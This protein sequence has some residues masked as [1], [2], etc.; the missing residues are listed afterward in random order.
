M[1]TYIGELSSCEE[2]FN[3]Y[4]DVLSEMIGR[5]AVSEILFMNLDIDRGVT[6]FDDLKDILTIGFYF[7][8]ELSISQN[9]T[10]NSYSDEENYGQFLLFIKDTKLKKFKFVD[11]HL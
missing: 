3:F 1:S 7:L 4:L 8:Q 2:A 9:Y 6:S 11:Q 10:V 5:C